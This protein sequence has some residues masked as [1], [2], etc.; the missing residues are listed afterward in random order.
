MNRPYKK[1]KEQEIIECFRIENPASLSLR[2]KY[3]RIGTP[4][5]DA[6]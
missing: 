1:D 6:V 2:A 3:G 4:G 5:G